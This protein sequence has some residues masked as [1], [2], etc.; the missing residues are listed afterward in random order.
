M[1]SGGLNTSL[2]MKLRLSKWISIDQTRNVSLYRCP[3]SWRA[4]RRRLIIIHTANLSEMVEGG[5]EQAGQVPTGIEYGNISVV[6]AS[7]AAIGVLR[8]TVALPAS[9]FV[10]ISELSVLD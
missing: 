3:N 6:P 5:V 2:V 9:E 1:L 10:Q 7:R 8:N 4:G